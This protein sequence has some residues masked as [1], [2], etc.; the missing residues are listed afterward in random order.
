MDSLNNEQNSQQCRA[1]RDWNE[2]DNLA[3]KDDGNDKVI[4]G[5]ERVGSGGRRE[6]E[7]NL[8]TR[9]QK[10]SKKAGTEK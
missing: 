1:C 2:D 6:R 4:N 10:Q 5:Q 8:N 9:K 3:R 7:D